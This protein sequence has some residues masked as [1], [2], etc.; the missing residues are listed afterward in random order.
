[1]EVNS[2]LGRKRKVTSTIKY[3]TKSFAP[4][5]YRYHLKQQTK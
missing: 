2:S 4:F 1:V 5:N 3:F